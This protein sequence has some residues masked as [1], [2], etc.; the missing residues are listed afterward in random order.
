MGNAKWIAEIAAVVA[1]LWGFSTL[2][3]A[4]TAEH[5][6]RRALRRHK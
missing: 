1:V 6:R 4:G 3:L 5:R 2:I